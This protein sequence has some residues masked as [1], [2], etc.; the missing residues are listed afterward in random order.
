V[1]AGLGVTDTATTAADDTVRVIVAVMPPNVAAIVHVPSATPLAR[2]S[3]EIVA[4]DG[5]EDV[6]VD[7]D[8]AFDVVPSAYV[9]IAVN[10]TV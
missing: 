9:A 3:V 7:R 1:V 6:H 8:V 2:P 4:T 5:F 10:C